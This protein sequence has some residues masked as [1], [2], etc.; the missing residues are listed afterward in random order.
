[1]NLKFILERSMELEKK[2]AEIYEGLVKKFSSYKEISEFW[3][4][5]AKDEKGHYERIVELIERL[6]P[7]QLSVEVSDDL[8]GKVCRGLRELRSER[9]KD[10]FDLDDACKLANEVEDYE[11]QA[12]F[13]FIQARFKHDV[14][15]LEVTGI[16]LAHLDKLASFSERCGSTDKRKLIKAA[17][18]G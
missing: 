10:I 4:D 16:I 1:M 2:Q 3:A 12:V 6:G 17:A 5:M 18:A 15:R 11:T 14:Y 9:L 8:Y 13:E 7:E